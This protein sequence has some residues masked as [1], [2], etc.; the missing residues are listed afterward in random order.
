MSKKGGSSHRWLNEHETD[1]YVQ[2]ARQE[3]YRSRAAFKLLELQEKD[4]LIKPGMKVVDL[5]AAPG[6]WTQIAAKLVGDSGHVFALDI[7]EMDP[8]HNAT[9]IQGDFQ[10]QA[11]L[12][13]L[14]SALNNTPV[15]L[16]ISDM[17]PNMSG[18]AA[19][20]QPRIMGLVELALDCASQILKPQGDFLAKVFQG[21]GFDD[22][23]REVRAQFKKVVIRKP[24]SSR[25]RSREVYVL[26]R[27]SNM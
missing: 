21:E 18:M 24:K 2:A 1:P 10:E 15:D 19:L 4:Q 5:G 11:V 20:D 13:Q 7:L 3:G 14:L 6:G 17:A 22:F 27:T 23:I 9:V 26:G 8:T 25:G 12:D 16:V